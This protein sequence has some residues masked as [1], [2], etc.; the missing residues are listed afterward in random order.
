MNTYV[1]SA[2]KN[3]LLPVLLQESYVE[4]GSWPDDTVDIWDDIAMKF[5]Q[6]PAPGKIR[7]VVN[8]MPAWVDAPLPTHEQ[9]VQQAERQKS[10]LLN[11]ASN[12]TN[13]WRTELALGIISDE[14]KA[15]L[16]VWMAYIKEIKALDVSKAPDITWPTQPSS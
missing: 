7:G 10:E 4:A 2:K 11:D 6:T 8:G 9:Y 3:Q 15:T 5:M 13:D 14:D 12:I 1:W 16:I